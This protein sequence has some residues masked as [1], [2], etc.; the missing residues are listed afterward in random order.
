MP[1]QSKRGENQVW[2]LPRVNASTCVE[3]KECVCVW[4]CVCV[5]VS[6]SVSVSERERER[7]SEQEF[8]CYKMSH[9]LSPFVVSLSPLKISIAAVVEREKYFC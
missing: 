5:S 8:G 4:V 2:A 1:G 9:F 3:V 6:V 7:A